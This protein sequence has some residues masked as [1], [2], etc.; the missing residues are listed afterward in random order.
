MILDNF[1]GKIWIS[2]IF[3]FDTI[4]GSIKWLDYFDNTSKNK[5]V[6]LTFGQTLK[7]ELLDPSA[8]S[9]GKV[10]SNRWYGPLHIPRKERKNMGSLKKSHCT[11]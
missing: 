7:N 11:L 4:L 8:Y 9:M 5:L 10:F 2:E 1:Y 6:S 3:T